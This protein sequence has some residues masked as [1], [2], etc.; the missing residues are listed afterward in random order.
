VR[1]HVIS[2]LHVE[3][4][5]FELPAVDADAVVLA[6]DI[7]LGTAGVRLARRWSHGRPVLFVAGNHDYYRHAL[8]ALTGELRAAA[9]GS[10]VHVLE[11]DEMVLDGVRFLGC[12]L[13]S[14]FLAAGKDE[15]QRSMAVCARMLNDYEV[16]TWSEEGRTLRPEDTRALHAASRR[17]LAGRLA[18]PH[19]G[20]TVVITHHAP[21]V[22]VHPPSPTHRALLGAFASDLTELMDG[23][24]AE[25]WIYGHMHVAADLEVEGTHV[26]SNPRGYP[27]EPVEDFDP[28][29]VVEVG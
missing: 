11:N 3:F 9:A 24:R 28:G 4:G 2:D 12:T 17:W 18:V 29:L 8:P 23:D 21:L 1:L 14:D 10:T 26:I 19:D 22:R 15:L 13:W 20:P 16:I 5:S 7:G 25:L 27:H 6:G